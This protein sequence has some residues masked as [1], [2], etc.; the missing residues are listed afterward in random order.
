MDRTTVDNGKE[1]NVDRVVEGQ[2]GNTD[3]KERNEEMKL[4]AEWKDGDNVKN[5]AIRLD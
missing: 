3:G 2:G 1:G 4:S 5:R